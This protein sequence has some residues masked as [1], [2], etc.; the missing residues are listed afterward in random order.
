MVLRHALRLGLA[1]ALAGCAQVSGLTEFDLDETGGGGAETTSSAS[2]A[3]G[4]GGGG[5]GGDEEGGGGTGGAPIATGPFRGIQPVTSLMSASDDDDPTFTANG[6]ELYFNTNRGNAR[7]WRATRSSVMDPWGAP[8][9]VSELEYDGSESNGVVSPSGGTFWV[10]VDDGGKTI[11]VSRRTNGMWSTPTFDSQQVDAQFGF[12]GAVDAAERR[13]V[14]ATGDL[15]EATRPTANDDW[16]PPSL[17]MAL[18]NSDK[19][20]PWM[21]PDG[22]HLYWAASGSIYHASRTSVDG[23]FDT[24]TTLPEL[25]VAGYL[26]DPWLTPDQSYIMF[27]VGLTD[28]QIYEAR[29]TMR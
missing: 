13:M 14:Y 18:G 21:S 24:P 12:V 26:S 19:E 7:M 9:A 11:F 29:R 27:A 25:E 3:A 5:A 16:S 22:L 6:L 15:H 2:G 17:I 20:A 1:L 23:A 10:M 4:A 28:R 8:G